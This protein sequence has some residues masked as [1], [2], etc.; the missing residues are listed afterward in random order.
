MNPVDFWKGYPKRQPLSKLA[1]ILLS[2]PSTS[3]SCERNWSTF[4][5]R[6]TKKRKKLT[7]LRTKKLVSIKSNLRFL[8]PREEIK[9]KKQTNDDEFIKPTDADAILFDDESD[10]LSD[11]DWQDGE[12]DDCQIFEEED[13]S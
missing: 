9:S 6:K 5:N 10:I 13:D 7:F 1:V 11:S 2:L 8:I 4:G 3:A 12:V